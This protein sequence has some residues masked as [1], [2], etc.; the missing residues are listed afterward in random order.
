MAVV[1]PFAPL[2]VPKPN[3]TARQS[4]T[5]QPEVGN[6]LKGQ[7]QTFLA[8]PENRAALLQFGIS[9]LAPPPGGTLASNIGSAIGQG[10]EARSRNISSQ[11]AGAE[12]AL[13]ARKTE[14]EIAE[15]V[16]QAGKAGRQAR[17]PGGASGTGSS[18]AAGGLT[19]KDYTKEKLKYLEGQK[20][21]TDL[22][23]EQQ[24]A[25]FD[26]M[27][28]AAT[29]RG[30]QQSTIAQMTLEQ[31]SALDKAS[32]TPAQL[33]EASARYQALQKK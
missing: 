10:A 8:Q 2:P 12:S 24:S 17:G 20:G 19:E 31:L 27:W 5:P 29:S 4:A 16:A 21:V 32:L 30:V 3:Q 15:N 26:E 22:S 14:S 9:M 11:A 6:D 13:A 7:W 1:K 23:L 28:N 33:T 25:E 18:K